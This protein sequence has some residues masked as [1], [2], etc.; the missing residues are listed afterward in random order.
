MVV[1]NH[2]CTTTTNEQC[3]SF[4]ECGVIVLFVEQFGDLLSRPADDTSNGGH[5]KNVIVIILRYTYNIDMN[6]DVPL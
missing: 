4:A 2:F 3:L 1:T 6:Y 5:Y